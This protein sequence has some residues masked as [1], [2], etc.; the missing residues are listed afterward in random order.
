MDKN[1][2]KNIITDILDKSAFHYSDV[3]ADEDLLN[4]FVLFAIKSDDSHNLIGPRGETLRALNHLVQ[5]ILEGKYG[6]NK[7]DIMIDVNGI[8]RKKIEQLK[9]TAY[10]MAERA[11]FFKSSVRVD[12]MSPYERKIIHAFL[13]GSKNIKTESDGMGKDRHVVIKY[14]PDEEVG[15]VV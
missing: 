13:S 12:P 2:I 14:I 8:E 1:E 6:E 15:F 7:I 4:G 10:M 3:V 5:K 9:T 11:R